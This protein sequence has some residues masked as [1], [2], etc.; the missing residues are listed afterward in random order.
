MTTGVVYLGEAILLHTARLIR[1]LSGNDHVVDLIIINSPGPTAAPGAY[2]VW[3]SEM[4][5]QQTRVD[6]VSDRSTSN[7]TY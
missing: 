3:V 1:T 5:L 2:A 7:I 6:T 4:M